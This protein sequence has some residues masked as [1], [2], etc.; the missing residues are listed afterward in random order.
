MSAYIA[1]LGRHLISWSSKKQRTVARSSTKAEYQ[2]VATTT[3]EINWI[4]SLLT[5]LGITLPTSP[6]I[7]CDN[8]GATYLCSNLVFH[9]T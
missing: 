7:Y 9:S 3:S 6:V 4:C 8:V 1:Y 2:L 5:E